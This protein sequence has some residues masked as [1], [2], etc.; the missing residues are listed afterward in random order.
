MQHRHEP[1]YVRT[2]N[3][4]VGPPGPDIRCGGGGGWGAVGGCV[5]SAG[6]EGGGVEGT[7]EG[8]RGGYLRVGTSGIWIGC[9]S[10]RLWPSY[11]VFTPPMGMRTG[12][13]QSIVARRQPELCPSERTPKSPLRTHPGGTFE[14]GVRG[15]AARLS[16][17]WRLR[18]DFARGSLMLQGLA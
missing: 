12:V 6:R 4:L 1:S 10:A 17:S 9:R 5:W 18:R 8:E 3:L 7:R 13:A 15:P 16:A 2:P 14:A 11:R